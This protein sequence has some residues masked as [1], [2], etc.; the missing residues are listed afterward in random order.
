ML[1]EMESELHHAQSDTIRTVV[2]VGAGAAFCAG[3]DLSGADTRGAAE[4]ANDVVQAITALA[5]PVIAGVHGAAAGFGCTLALACDVI[6]ASPA[7]YFQ[8]A[9]ARVGLM[10]DGGATA[11]LH[12]VIGRARTTRMAMFAEKVSGQQAFDWG[13]VSHLTGQDSFSEDLEA[14]V[15]ALACGPTQSYKWIKRTLAATALADLRAI[16]QLEARGQE[17]LVNTNDFRAGVAAF[18]SRSTPSFEGR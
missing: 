11:L 17:T 13:M 18:H 16:Q 10:P 4:A 3:G 1:R 5:K 6:V 8:L 7:A 2:L 14:V 15:Q 9:F 12:A